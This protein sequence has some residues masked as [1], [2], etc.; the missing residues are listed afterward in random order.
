MYHYQIPLL[1]QRIETQRHLVGA[2]PLRKQ[3]PQHEQRKQACSAQPTIQYKWR[4]PIENVLVL[5]L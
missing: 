1:R 5:T 2:H 4:P 3:N